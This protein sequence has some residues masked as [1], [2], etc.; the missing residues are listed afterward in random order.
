MRSKYKSSKAFVVSFVLHFIAGVIGFFFWT[1]DQFVGNQDA[2]SAVLM[3]VEE[4][5][6]KR[7]NRP[8]RPQVRRQKA[9]VQT[10]QPH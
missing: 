8:K 2:I 4:P 3:K 6:R 5:K 7:M 9:N 1:S 10:N